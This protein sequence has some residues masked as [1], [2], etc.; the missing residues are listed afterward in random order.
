MASEARQIESR[1][2]QGRAAVID[3]DYADARPERVQVL[4]AR[5]VADDQGGRARA[6]RLAEEPVAVGAF[7][8]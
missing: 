4:V 8:R 5:R 6:D 3:G 1:P 2:P 7:A